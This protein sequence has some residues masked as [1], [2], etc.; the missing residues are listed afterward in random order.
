[1]CIQLPLGTRN[2]RSSSNCV[3]VPSW[4]RVAPKCRL[5]QALAKR[6]VVPGGPYQYY[7]VH[8]YSVVRRVWGAS[9]VC[10][11]LVF[12]PPTPPQAL[13]AR[14][15]STHVRCNPIATIVKDQE[16]TQQ[17]Y[18]FLIMLFLSFI[19]TPSVGILGQQDNKQV[20]AGNLMRVI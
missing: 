19:L 4:S 16:D 14:L 6:I 12:A 5:G 1:M 18:G 9:G 10:K 17:S 3:G 11:F 7:A 13:I 20:C 8:Q 15:L 2:L